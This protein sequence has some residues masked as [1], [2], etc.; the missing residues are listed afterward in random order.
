MSDMDVDSTGRLRFVRVEA[1]DNSSIDIQLSNG[2]IV[3]LETKFILE[4]PGFAELAEDDRILY[5]RTEGE[6][7]FWRNG[8][9]PLTVDEILTLVGKSDC[10]AETGTKQGGGSGHEG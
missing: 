5:P 10:R 7:I 8:P 6:T 9:R 1:A 2:N 4:L 3:I